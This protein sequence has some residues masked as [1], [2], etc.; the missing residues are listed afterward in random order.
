MYISI[1]AYKY[2]RIE[3]FNF[4]FLCMLSKSKQVQ[5]VSETPIDRIFW[6]T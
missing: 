6:N 2:S 5:D 1:Y 3:N 4:V